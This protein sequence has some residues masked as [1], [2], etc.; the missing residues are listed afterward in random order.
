MTTS[1]GRPT[2]MSLTVQ[3]VRYLTKYVRY[4]T[5]V[6]SALV[7][8]VCD[9]DMAGVDWAALA[10]ILP[11][12]DLI[13]AVDGRPADPDLGPNALLAGKAGKPVELTLRR[14]HHVRDVQVGGDIVIQGAEVLPHRHRGRHP[15]PGRL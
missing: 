7:R 11:P 3:F 6:S 10:G 15:Y 13:V 8:R 2:G 1:S 4:L 9:P 14:D 12:G 5:N